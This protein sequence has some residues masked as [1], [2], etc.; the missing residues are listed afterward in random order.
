MV[1]GFWLVVTPKEYPVSFTFQDPFW[2]SV[3]FLVKKVDAILLSAAPLL[4]GGN[5]NIFLFSPRTL[6]K[7]NPF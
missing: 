5:S 7:M 3:F 2:G 1:N 6:R 4:G